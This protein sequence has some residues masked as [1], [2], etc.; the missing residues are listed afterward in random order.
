MNVQP[1]MVHRD[2]NQDL[3]EMILNQASEHGYTSIVISYVHRNTTCV[4]SAC[5]LTHAYIGDMLRTIIARADK[6]TGFAIF[7][8]HYHD[9]SE[10]THYIATV[11]VR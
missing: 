10:H 1:N 9:R 6:F 11:R 7:G 8:S 4:N 3:T 5:V 2:P